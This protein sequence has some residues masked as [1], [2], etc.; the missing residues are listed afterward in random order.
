MQ[1]N[2][3]DEVMRVA[4]CRTERQSLLARHHSAAKIR[5]VGA[6]PNRF[7]DFA[8]VKNHHCRRI[9]VAKALVAMPEGPPIA[10]IP[11]GSKIRHFGFPLHVSP[12]APFPHLSAL[13]RNVDPVTLVTLVTLFFFTRRETRM[14]LCC[15]VL[16]ATKT[17]NDPL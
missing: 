14:S 9:A 4:R 2:T 3:P 15:T 10:A 16:F 1:A 6:Q 17:A 12:S 5:F 8:V 7:G 13:E 11:A